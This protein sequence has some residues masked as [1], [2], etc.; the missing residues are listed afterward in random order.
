MYSEKTYSIYGLRIR[1]S[2]PLAAESV[3]DDPN[4]DLLVRYR[5][6]MAPPVVPAPPALS[7]EWGEEQQEWALRYRTRE[8]H[9]LDF[10]LNKEGTC[11]DVYCTKPDA[12]DDIT[13]VFL[14]PAV[15]SILHLRGFPILHAAAVVVDGMAILVAGPSGAGKSTLTAALISQGAPLLAEDL[16]VLRFSETSIDVQPG[17]PRLRLCPD[18]TAVADKTASDLPRVFRTLVQDDKRWVKAADLAGGFCTTPVPLGPIYLLAPRRQNL[19]AA[20]IVPLPSHRAGLTLLGHLY[21]TRW[22]RISQSRALNWCAH[23]ARNSPVRTVEA[24]TGLDRV[25]ESAAAIIANAR[26]LA[27]STQ[28]ITR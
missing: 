11:L 7:V 21:G 12:I 10:R 4:V 18:A 24:P 15:A 3:L 17:Y 22:L 16:A 2:L 14:G 6:G 13:A 26:S 8:G 9:A 5:G 28:L 25:C 20:E 1:S 27:A 19:P 23:I